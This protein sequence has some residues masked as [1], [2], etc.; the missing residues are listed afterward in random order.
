MIEAGNPGEDLDQ[1]LGRGLPR[2]TAA[3]DERRQSDLAH[4]A[5]SFMA[6][7]AGS[8]RFMWKL[9]GTFSTG[10]PSTSA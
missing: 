3:R 10:T 2:S 1:V 6:M 7:A 9:A 5:S 8:S 4:G